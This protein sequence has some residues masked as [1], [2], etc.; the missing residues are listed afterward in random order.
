MICKYCSKESE[1][2]KAFA[3]TNHQ[4]LTIE[5]HDK[6]HSKQKE[7]SM[8]GKFK[9]VIIAKS[10]PNVIWEKNVET[11]RTE[12]EKRNPGVLIQEVLTNKEYL[13]KGKVKKV[14]KA[15]KVEASAPVVSVDETL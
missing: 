2:Q 9:F 13:K 10:E 8:I 1:I 14:K 3:P 7:F 6:V 5:E 11:A 15:V 4:W 12:F